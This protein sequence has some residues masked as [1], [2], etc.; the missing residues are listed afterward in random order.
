M[1]CDNIIRPVIGASVDSSFRLT[2]VL[3]SGRPRVATKIDRVARDGPFF[4]DRPVDAFVSS[5]RVAS[6]RA[7]RLDAGLLYLRRSYD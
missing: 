4:G 5:R 3:R 2:S 7:V 6:R 1:L